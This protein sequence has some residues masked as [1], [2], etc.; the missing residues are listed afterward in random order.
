MRFATFAV[1]SA[2][3]LGASAAPAS[4]SPHVVHERRDAVP[5]GWLKHERVSDEAVL[6]M[7][8]GLTQQNLDK[9]YDLLMDV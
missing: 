2:L 1:V 8:I 5:R 4:N 9:G 7:R 6:P 3:A